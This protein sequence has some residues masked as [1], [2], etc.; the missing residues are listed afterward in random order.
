MHFGRSALDAF[1]PLVQKL[2]NCR[3]DGHL[4][5]M[6]TQIIP[7]NFKNLKLFAQ[8]EVAEFGYTHV[9]ILGLSWHF[10]SGNYRSIRWHN[11]MSPE[12]DFFP[13]KR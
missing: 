3:G 6:R 1:E 9:E 7:D 11:V 8:R 13:L 5:H 2:T 4:F 10:A 12:A